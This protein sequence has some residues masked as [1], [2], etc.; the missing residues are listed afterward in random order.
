MRNALLFVCCLA[1]CTMSAAIRWEP[2]ALPPEARDLHADLGHLTVPLNRAHPDAGSAE[3]AFVRLRAGDGSAN[4]PIVYLAGGPGNSGVDAAR[5][6]YALPS[7]A[8][9]A[10]VGDVI[11]LDQRGIGLSTPH[12]ACKATPLPPRERFIALPAAVA[13]YAER[14]R[15]CVAELASNGIDVSAFNVRESA[16][17]VDELRQALGVPKVSLLAHSYGT[18][19]A[20]SVIRDY[21]ANIHRAVLLGTAG[22]ND[23]RK[24]P[25]MLDTQLGKLALLAAGDP[26]VGRDVPD[27][28]ALLRRVLD[29]LEKK[30][31]DVTVTDRATKELVTFPVGPDTLRSFLVA[32]IGDGNDFPFFPALLLT[33]ERGDPSI[34]EW[35][36]EKRYNQR[37]AGVDL[38]VLGMRCSAGAT[39]ARDREIEREASLSL[40]RNAVNFPFPDACNALPSIDLGDAFRAPI[41]SN[42]SVLFMSGTLDSNTPPYQAE[43]VR[44]GMPNATHLIVDNAGHEDLEPNEDVQA[45]I[46]DYLAGKDVAQRRVS[47]PKPHFLSVDD[48]KKQRRA[49]RFGNATS[50]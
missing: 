18:Y 49:S 38:M 48:A 40:F 2:F 12:V 35:F 27:L 20:L 17:D 23:M 21:G 13:R 9:L 6:P 32:D 19:L 46:A 42:A 43:A 1:A 10:R 25:L 22:P 4:P 34:L 36:A 5:N 26:A 15:A 29:K 30:P 14:T 33:I 28:A 41:V 44:W 47:L 45:I 7:L 31:I 50:H 39:A 3:L 24:L 11:L 8:R 16:A 37:A